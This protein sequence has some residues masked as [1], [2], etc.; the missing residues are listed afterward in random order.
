MDARNAW[1]HPAYAVSTPRLVIRCWERGDVD[2]L[3][4]AVLANVDALRPW[5]PWIEHEPLDRAARVERVR[6]SRGLFDLGEDFIYGIFDA[7]DGRVLGGTGLHTRIGPGALE[8]GYWIVA[9]RWGEG[10]ATEV[11]GALTR[12]GFE[13][14]KAHRMEIR[15]TPENTRSQSVPR[16]LGYREEGTLRAVAEARAGTGERTDLI[17]FA[18]LPEELA[19]SP[20]AAIPIRTETFG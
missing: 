15:V 8:I 10:L 14:M 4:D 11:A 3:H 13:I 18:M 12:V 7:N 1:P 6:S 2:G 5:M 9:D 16:K 19:E 17:V 20:A